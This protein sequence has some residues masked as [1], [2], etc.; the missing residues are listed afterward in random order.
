MDSIY[1]SF[2]DYH[3]NRQVMMKAD[4][5]QVIDSETV[6][7]QIVVGIREGRYGEMILDLASSEYRPAQ[8][9]PEY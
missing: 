5:Y 8:I 3:R 2:A 1:I 6:I 4:T 7:G 9:G